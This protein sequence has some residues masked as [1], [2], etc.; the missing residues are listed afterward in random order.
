M[1]GEKKHINVRQRQIIEIE[2]K[3]TH[4]IWSR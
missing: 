1:E 3:F 2:A 4:D